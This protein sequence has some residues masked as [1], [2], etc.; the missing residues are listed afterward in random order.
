MFFTRLSFKREDGGV[1][2]KVSLLYNGKGPR[3]LIFNFKKRGV[4]RFNL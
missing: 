3:V 2:S 4:K 1:V